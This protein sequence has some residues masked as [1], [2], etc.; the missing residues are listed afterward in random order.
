M[1][2]PGREARLPR[3]RIAVLVGLD[4]VLALREL[5]RQPVGGPASNRRAFSPAAFRIVSSVDLPDP[6]AP[7]TLMRPVGRARISAIASSSEVTWLAWPR[8][9][10]R[11][12]I[13]LHARVEP[14][15][16]RGMHV[17]GDA[18]HAGPTRQ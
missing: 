16:G 10:K 17:V 18:G 4:L 2:L 8:L 14:A 5:E 3:Q 15:V 13:E 6:L 7:R 11:Q 9:A 1:P 12:P